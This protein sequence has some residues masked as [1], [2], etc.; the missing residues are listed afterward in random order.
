MQSL[1]RKLKNANDVGGA[2]LSGSKESWSDLSQ[3]TARVAVHA[4][5]GR[6]GEGRETAP[7]PASGAAMEV[8]R[9]AL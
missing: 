7:C 6:R 1:M 4:A 2:L 3:E 9:I 8:L 5:A